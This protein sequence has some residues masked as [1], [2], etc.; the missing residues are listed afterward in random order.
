M[1]LFDKN[2]L[3]LGTDGEKGEEIPEKIDIYYVLAWKT[4]CGNKTKETIGD[5]FAETERYC[6]K[7]ATPA[8]KGGAGGRGGFGG[9]HGDAKII[10]LENQSNIAIFN[11]NGMSHFDEPFALINFVDV[12][13]WKMRSDNIFIGC[14]KFYN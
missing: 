1:G 8:G 11:E 7:P 14:L 6:G 13:L 4:P 9:I 5:D 2:L 12:F 3:N 10:G